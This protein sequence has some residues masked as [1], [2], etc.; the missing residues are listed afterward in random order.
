MPAVD[1]AVTLQMC[2]TLGSPTLSKLRNQ[3]ASPCY[4]VASTVQ[5]QE[6]LL[7]FLA[8]HTQNKTLA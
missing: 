5:N 6:G 2:S 8:V 7:C 1:V 3:A 4:I